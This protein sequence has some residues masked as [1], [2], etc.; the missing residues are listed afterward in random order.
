MIWLSYNYRGLANPKK[1]LAFKRLAQDTRCDILFLQETLCSS[2]ISAR[3][4]QTIL[5]G[6]IFQGL[7]ANGKSGGLAIGINPKTVKNISSWGG[8]GFIGMDIFMGKLGLTLKVINI[9]APNQN[10]MAFWLNLLENNLVTNS[11]IIGGDLNFSL[12]MEESWGHHA[13]L[14]PI[15]EQMSTLLDSYKLVDVP[16]NKKVPTWHKRRT[17]EAALGWRLD[18]FLIHEDLIHKLPLYRQWVGTGG[19]SDHLPI[20]LQVSGPIKKPHSPIKLFSGHLQDPDFINLVTDFWGSQPPLRAQRMAADFCERL[21]SLRIKTEDWSKRKRLRDYQHLMDIEIHIA[22]LMDERGLGFQSKDSK[23]LLNNLEKQKIKLLQDKEE[24]WRL[25]SRAIW[26][27]AG[28]RNTKFFHNLANG[29]KASNTIW[30]LPNE[31]EGWASTHQQLAR[32]GISHFKRQFT[33]P[34]A[35]NLSE[36]INEVGHFP[37]FIEPEAVEDLIQLVTMEELE[38]TLKWFKKDKSLGPDD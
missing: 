36:I 18:R 1:H 10:I 28:D 38:G 6:W 13:Q 19:L 17:G 2:D 26:L 11:T 5:P 15:L 25:K 7:D 29:R 33:A 37:R 16:M 34:T 4:L 3:T 20:F 14:D 31:P 35:I 32:F 9:Y 30:K 21:K 24:P 12:G 27:Q 8:W 22:H 23:L